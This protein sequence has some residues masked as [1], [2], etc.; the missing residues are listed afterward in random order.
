MFLWILLIDRIFCWAL[1]LYMFVRDVVCRFVFAC[2][3]ACY[4]YVGWIGVWFALAALGF[5]DA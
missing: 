1:C 3:V 4:V 2:W 5:D